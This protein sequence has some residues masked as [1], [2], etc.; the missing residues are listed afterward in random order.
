MLTVCERVAV[1]EGL[2]IGDTKSCQQQSCGGKSGRM[3]IVAWVCIESKLQ[4]SND[5][6]YGVSGGDEERRAGGCGNECVFK[7][8]E[9]KR[10]WV[11][12]QES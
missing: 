5:G 4:S 3:H 8:E 6:V 11:V 7:S 10:E 1:S 9:E 12:V 2:R